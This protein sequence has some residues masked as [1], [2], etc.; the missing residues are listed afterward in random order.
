MT[1]K[2]KNFIRFTDQSLRDCVVSKKTIS[3]VGLNQ[4]ESCRRIKENTFDETAS[5]IL[6]AFIIVF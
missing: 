5:N 1:G 3:V 6:L 4:M 2:V